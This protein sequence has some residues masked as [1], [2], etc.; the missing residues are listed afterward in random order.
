MNNTNNTEELLKTID[1]TLDEIYKIIKEGVTHR[2][3]TFGQLRGLTT[4]DD[5]VQE[6]LLYYLSTMKSTGDIRLNHYIKKYQDR[7]HIVNLIKQTSYQLPLYTLR[8]KEAV[9]QPLSLQMPYSSESTGYVTMTLEDTI[10]DEE[11]ENAIYDNVTNKELTELLRDELNR[12]NICRLRQ[13]YKVNSYD[14]FNLP[15][16][17]DTSNYVKATEKTEEQMRIIKDLSEGCSKN[18]LVKK[19]ASFR[20]D[21]EIIRYAFLGKLHEYLRTQ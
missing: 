2:Y 21:M 6:V 9:N 10:M 16:L 19:Y 13:T 3:S 11:A 14:E 20:E 8:S 1:L 12:L 5:M 15:F 4:P 18:S 17:L 7:Q